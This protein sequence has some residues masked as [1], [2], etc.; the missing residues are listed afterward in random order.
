MSSFTFPENYGFVFAGVFGT[1]IANLYCSINVSKH[2]KKFGIKYPALYADATHIN[3][4]CKKED[5]ETFNCAQR[6]H[7]NTLESLSS[8]QLMGA[9]NGLMFPQFAASCLGVYSVGRILYC[10]G[11]TKNGPDGRMLGGIVSHLGDLPLLICTGYCAY[12]LIMG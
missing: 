5:V 7:Q 2:R 10:N 11:Y 12:T 6:A 4:D 8:V 1:M 9:L 3:K